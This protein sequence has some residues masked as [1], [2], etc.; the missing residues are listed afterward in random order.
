MDEIKD[1]LEIVRE[2]LDAYDKGEL[3]DLSTFIAI[4]M[5]VSPKEPSREAILW[6]KNSHVVIKAREHLKV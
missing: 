5:T 1:K 3:S 6:A 4:K 2:A